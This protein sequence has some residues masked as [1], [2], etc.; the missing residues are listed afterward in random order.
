[1]FVVEIE[2]FPSGEAFLFWNNDPNTVAAGGFPEQK[3]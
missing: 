3:G 1:M 2:L